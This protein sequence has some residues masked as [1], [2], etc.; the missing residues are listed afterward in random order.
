MKIQLVIGNEGNLPGFASEAKV[1]TEALVLPIFE[2]DP[3]TSLRVKKPDYKGVVAQFLKDHPKFGKLYETQLIYEGRGKTLLVG[4]GKGGKWDIE[5]FQN[6]VGTATK[7][8]LGKFTDITIIPRYQNFTPEKAGEAFGLGVELATHDPSRD[9]KSLDKEIVKLGGVNLWVDKGDKG[10]LDGIKRGQ[11]IAEALN[12]VRKLGDMPANEMTPS[13]FLKEAKR[14]AKECKLKLIVI[15]E[16]Q[17]KKMGMGGFVGVAKGSDEPSYIIVLEY[18]GSRESKDEKWGL[19]GKGITFDSGGISIK[20]SQSM[21]EMK[22]DMCGAGAVL[23]VMQVLPKL[24][25]K[26]N[27]VGVMCVTE[28]LPGG[29][30]Q[31]PGDIVKLYSG[32]T[33]EILNT[34]AEGRLVLAD[35]LA[36]VQ[37]KGA[38]K[39]ID[40]A[41]LTGACVVALGGVCSGAM[42]NNPKFTQDV[43]IAGSNVGE[44]IWELPMYEDYAEMIKSDIAD[45][46]N[47][48][49][50]GPM[51]GAAGVI[52]AAKFLESAVEKDTPWVHLDIAGTAWDLKVKPFRGPGATG[53]GV[54]TLVEL[55]SK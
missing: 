55:I 48:G 39:L 54:K 46:T 33:A 17:A 16:S 34:D 45:I 50:G 30:A 19:V 28:N 4:A 53:V 43:I 44:R 32:K 7:Y 2:D 12:L 35:G 38:T 31:R 6:W 8:A 11:V 13:Y 52:T 27:A 51:P 20:P 26:V 29:R 24:K 23:G 9:Y 15:D 5:K 37:A 3:S 22:Y 25:I 14:V 18:Q 36:L 10:Y 40:L 1:K 49:I 47:I 21:H 41:T 42:G